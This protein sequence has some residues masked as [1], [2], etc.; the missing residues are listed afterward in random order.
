VTL[1]SGILFLGYAKVGSRAPLHLFDGGSP[2]IPR[3]ATPAAPREEAGGTGAGVSEPVPAGRRIR[4]WWE[5]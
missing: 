2:P 5:H 1:V 4:P 3:H